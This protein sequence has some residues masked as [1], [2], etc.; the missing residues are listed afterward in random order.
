MSEEWQKSFQEEIE[1]ALQAKAKGNEGRARVCARR[2]VKHI[3]AEYLRREN[4]H[5]NTQ[6]AYGLIRFFTALPSLSSEVREVARHFLVKV[7]PTGSLPIDV[8]L[9]TEALWLCETLLEKEN[10]HSHSNL[11]CDNNRFC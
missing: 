7:T 6:S 5:A 3:I 11:P 4:I 10:S 8:D 2:A 1:K 9:I